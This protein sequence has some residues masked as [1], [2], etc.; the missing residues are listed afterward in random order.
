MNTRKNRKYILDVLY[1]VYVEIIPF[2][3]ILGYSKYVTNF[4]LLKTLMQLQE[5]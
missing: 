1:S 3:S 4:T 5:I 2:F